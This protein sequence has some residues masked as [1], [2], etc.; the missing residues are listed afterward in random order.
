MVGDSGYM[1]LRSNDAGSKSY[2]IVF[3]S[4]EQ[5]H[6]FNFPF[7]L[8]T[9]GDSPNIAAT[10]T[11]EIKHN[12]IVIVGTDGLFDNLFGEQI[13]AL[14][15]HYLTTNDYN[16][17]SLAKFLAEV[18]Y[19]V[20]LDPDIMTPFANGARRSKMFFKGGKSDDITVV[21]GRICD[22]ANK[23]A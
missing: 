16:S 10:S 5:Q 21:V 4:T 15:N 9:H 23:S 1:L 22:E 6:S 7:Q 2:E 17:E 18:T 19:Q 13:L 20:S 8:G 14:V 11:H 3:K 12:D